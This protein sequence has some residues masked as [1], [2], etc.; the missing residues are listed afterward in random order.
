MHKGRRECGLAGFVSST[1]QSWTWGAHGPVCAAWVAGMGAR[2]GQ[3]VLGVT[4]L[5]AHT[6]TLDRMPGPGCNA[7]S[8]QGRPAF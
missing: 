3:C 4:A 2:A 6:L 7:G 8:S 5:P 1:C